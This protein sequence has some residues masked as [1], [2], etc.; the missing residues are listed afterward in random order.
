VTTP[1][2]TN[3]KLHLSSPR[4]AVDAL[5]AVAT[6]LVVLIGLLVTHTPVADIV[7][8]A[9]FVLFTVL[10]P[11]VLA[12]RALRGRNP[13]LVADLALGG[14]TGVGLSLLAWAVF[15]LGGVQHY[16]WM[17]PL[18]VYVPFLA[19]PRLRRHWRLGGHTERSRVSSWLLAASISYFTLALVV[20]TIRFEDLPPK[21]TQYNTDV[22][23]HI[24]NAAELTRHLP[25]AV[26]SVAGRAL[27]YHW[28]FDAFLG[29]SHLI[30]G[31]DLPTLMV[32]F[33]EIP[34]TAL[35]LG[36]TVAV[37]RKA[38]GA[39]WPGALAALILAG[40]AQLAPWAWYLPW[41]SNTFISGSPSLA[42]GLVPLLLA[43][44]VLIG[45]IRGENIRAGGWL[46]LA[47]A[48]LMGPGSKPSPVL[49]GGMGCVLLVNLFQRKPVRRILAATAMVVA[50]LVVLSPLVAQATAASGIKL[51]GL[52]YFIPLWTQYNPINDLPST[53][54]LILNG[55][56]GHGI[57]AL[58]L[59]A[60][61][62]LQFAVV[63]AAIP[64]LRRRCRTD[65]AVVFMAGGFLAG[66]AAAMVV[67]HAGGGEI[68]FARTAVPFGTILATWGLYVALPRGSAWRERRRML[69]II[70]GA[71]VLGLAI[72][73]ATVSSAGPIPKIADYPRAI[74]IP[75]GVLVGASL[76]AFA[77]WW[78]LRRSPALAGTGMALFC[79]T[80]IVVLMIQGPWQTVKLT[81]DALTTTR[82]PLPAHQVTRGETVAAQWVQ[83]NVPRDEIIATNVHCR[84]KKT[85]N[86]CD[87][88]AFWVAAFTERRLLVESWAYTEEALRQIG[89]QPGSPMNFT[90]DDPAL[91]ALNEKAFHH[92]T[93]QDL[94]TLRDEYHVK[95][96]F[97]DR[98]ASPVSP[99]L[100]NL[101]TLRLSNHEVQVY[102]LRSS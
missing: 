20:R 37:S 10:L 86:R 90:F 7:R 45:L 31:V 98:L 28:F 25:P 12:H 87:V 58:L 60:T 43:A 14:A 94:A 9:A 54:G 44:H 101:A 80:T 24:A 49:L 27:R 88:R 66:V 74:A 63:L 39:L 41:S 56:P 96:L 61:I 71:V 73:L 38:T 68:Y 6:G 32:R 35:V 42:F 50:S 13:L 40:W 79:A 48:V 102:E 67:D 59:V 26:P 91:F 52:V 15:M 100:K 75:L 82:P 57:F 93:A 18:A 78:L 4:L 65:G 83:R 11:G 77:A 5:P 23:W 99:N 16:L 22:Y 34:L 97:A 53:G 3:S 72:E 89:D 19:V 84:Y 2:S 36:L 95:W 30:S 81:D 62:L 33:W 47:L 17:W 8:Y 92:P 76:L 69:A 70:G 46:V 85:V 51:F 55:I 29:E 21:P 64:L 1:P